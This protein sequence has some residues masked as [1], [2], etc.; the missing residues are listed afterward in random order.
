M[1]VLFYS[2]CRKF[3]TLAMGNVNSEGDSKSS[4]IIVKK[5]GI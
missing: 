2:V 5:K 4:F 3:P 1:L